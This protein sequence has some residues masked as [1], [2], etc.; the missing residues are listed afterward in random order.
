M[1]VVQQSVVIEGLISR[2]SLVCIVST[3]VYS[4]QD[5]GRLLPVISGLILSS[6]RHNH[7]HAWLYE[8]GCHIRPFQLLH[9]QTLTIPPKYLQN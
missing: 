2:I 4:G 7:V 8:W 6:Q 1:I 9:L 5:V 3:R